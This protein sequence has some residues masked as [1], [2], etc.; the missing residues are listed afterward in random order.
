MILNIIY[1]IIHTKKIAISN[2]DSFSNVP[3]LIF[4]PRTCLSSNNYSLF[5]PL[6]SIISFSFSNR[7]LPRFLERE[8][9]GRERESERE[10]VKLVSVH[11]RHVSIFGKI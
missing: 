11:G 10:R 8:G 7:E 3:L 9:R 5:Y 4:I 6:Q 2:R 1:I